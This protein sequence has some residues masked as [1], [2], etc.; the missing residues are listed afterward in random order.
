MFLFVWVRGKGVVEIVVLV[1][2]VES[3]VQGWF[4][5][6]M[7]DVFDV[8]FYVVILGSDDREDMYG[9]KVMSQQENSYI[10]IMLL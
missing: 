2:Q 10:V 8:G 1:K 3:E 6:F 7:E 9:V 5:N 4:F